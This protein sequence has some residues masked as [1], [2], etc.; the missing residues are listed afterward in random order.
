MLY[1]QV[2]C[3]DDVA[4]LSDKH[5][6]TATELWS[7]EGEYPHSES[8]S[9]S[10]SIAYSTLLACKLEENNRN[11]L[12]A[13]SQL[14]DGFSHLSR[15]HMKSNSTKAISANSPRATSL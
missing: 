4:S 6:G 10:L 11:S 5:K 13:G 12:A 2:S 1:C 9:S 14:G 7:V 15:E 8:C 3:N